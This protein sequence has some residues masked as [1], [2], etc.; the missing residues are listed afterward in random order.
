LSLNKTF[1]FFPFQ[2][3]DFDSINKANNDNVDAIN[4]NTAFRKKFSPDPPINNDI[5]SWNQA[6]SQ[7]HPTQISTT[8]YHN[9]TQGIQ[10]GEADQYYHLTLDEYS[11]ISELPDKADKVVNAIPGNF[12][13]LNQHGNLTDSGNKPADFEAAGAVLNH[14]SS[15]DHTKLH[16]PVTAIDSSDIDFTLT[17]QSITAD[18]SQTTVT[19]G[20]YTNANITVD[21]KGR[22]T[23]ASNGSPAGPETDP[24]VGAVNGIVKADGS[25]NISTAAAG[26]DYQE[27]LT[28]GTDYEVPLNF[29]TGLTRT[30]NTVDCEITQY[31]DSDAVA[32]IKADEDWNAADW[33]TA[34]NWGDHA[35]L[36]DS[37]GTAAS[38]VGDHETAYNHDD[39]DSH[40]VCTTNPHYVT[41]DQVLPLQAGNGGK[42]LKTDGSTATW[43]DETGGTGTVSYYPRFSMTGA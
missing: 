11:C 13:G 12:A 43:Q 7:W 32:V 31:T 4:L 20:S 16:D 28:S 2:D 30:E 35:G 15:F 3:D 5:W 6:T 37:V 21:T 19:P 39:Y 36:Y 1:G 18:L 23:A 24:V 25:G 34:F 33:D 14:Q 10:G 9:E 27:P 26:V 22:V 8:V 38:A 40:I 42:V 41:A 29:G 17:G